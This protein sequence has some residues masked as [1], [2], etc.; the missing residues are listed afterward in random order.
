MNHLLII[1]IDS[2][3]KFSKPS[4]RLTTCVK[5]VTDFKYVLLEKYEFDRENIVELTDANATNINIQNALEKYVQILDKNSNLIIYFSGHGGLRKS[6]Q[7]GYWIPTNASEEDYST[8]LPNEVILESVK[9][10]SAKHVFIISDC[11]FATSLLITEPSKS[12]NNITLDNYRSRWIL[13]SGREETYC[14][15][16]GENSF[17]G[18][19]LLTILGNSETD[20]RV[21]TI[22]EFVKEKFKSNL[23][24]QPQG[25]PIS[26]KH[27]DCGEFIFKIKDPKHLFESDIKGYNLFKKVIDIYSKSSDVE[28]IE[29]FEDKTNKIGFTLLRENDKLKKEVSHYLYLYKGSNQSRTHSYIN[30]KHKGILNR[31]TIIFIPKEED[32]VFPERRLKNIEK[33]F[34]PKNISYI[35][36]FIQELSSKSI[37]KQEKSSYLNINNFILPEFSVANHKQKI[38]IEK[39]LKTT[40]SPLLVIKGTAGIGKTTYAKY[41]SDLFQ[42]SNR[43]ESNSMIL[44]IDS[45]EIQEELLYLQKVGKKLDLYSFYK[46]ANAHEKALDKELF[47]INLDAGNLLLIIDGLDEIISRNLSFDI[48]YFFKSISP[49]SFGLGN[50]KIIITTR[51]YFWDKTNINNDLLYSIELLPFDLKRAKVFFE[52]TFKSDESKIKRAL[53]IAEDFKLPSSETEYYYHPFVLDIIKEIVLSNNE[54]LFSDKAFSSQSLRSDLKVDYIIGRI[55]ERE[56][57][58]VQQISVDKQISFF[59]HLAVKEHGKIDEAAIKDFLITSLKIQDISLSIVESFKAH[60]FLHFDVETKSM[61]FKYDFFESYFISLFISGL[62][63]INQETNIDFETLKLLSQKLYHGSDTIKN[64]TKRVSSWDDGNLLKIGDMIQKIRDFSIDDFNITKRAISGLFNLALAVNFNFKSNSRVYNTQLV[65]DLFINSSNEIEH[66]VVLNVTSLEENIRFDFSNLTFINCIFENYS[67]FWECNQN[68]GTYYRKCSLRNIGSTNKNISIPREN[69][70]DCDDDN[71]LF[72]VFSHQQTNSNIKLEKA[73]AFLDDFFRIFYKKGQFKKIS[74][75]LLTESQN[76]PRINKYGIK[77][78]ELLGILKQENFISY[79]EHKKYNDT[80]IGIHPNKTEDV[81]KFCFEG[82]QNIALIKVIES[83]ADKI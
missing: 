48:D 52:K 35:E 74:D 55:C 80:K 17:F 75:S 68:S 58:R 22:I 28:E 33:I 19:S 51:T 32:Q 12:I 26:D 45:N 30:E 5:D 79:I 4:D 56:V 18:E 49:S 78:N 13:T 6:T 11:C 1:G 44:F 62:L 76:Y 3:P 63:N 69:F 83:I 10:M 8:W 61:S 73:T 23:L 60:P 27:H 16:F 39:W 43:N 38:E 15:S 36:D 31:N 53:S 46:A 2:Y 67:L 66:L 71:S 77:L 50:T 47:S 37:E 9:K 14:G 34:L 65:K 82:K 70:I 64:I 57:K 21:G 41:I 7:K 29:N 59:I 40:N 24:Q 42:N 72:N 81:S 20:L 54:I 25:H